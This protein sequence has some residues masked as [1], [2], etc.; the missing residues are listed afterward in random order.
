MADGYTS[1]VVKSEPHAYTAELVV[2]TTSVARTFTRLAAALSIHADITLQ[3]RIICIIIPPPVSRCRE[4]SNVVLTVD[5][6][7]VSL[8]IRSIC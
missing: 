8:I 5:E 3:M 6:T 7:W 1:A 4:G 2:L